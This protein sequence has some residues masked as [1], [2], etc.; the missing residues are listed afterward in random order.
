MRALIL[1]LT[2]CLA[3]AVGGGNIALAQTGDTLARADALAA[4][5]NVRGALALYEEAARDQPGSSEAFARLGGMQLLDQRYSEAV[6]SFQR[7][8]SLGDSGARPF[9]G[10]GMAYLHMGQLDLARAAFVEARTRGADASAE[11]ASVIAWIDSRRD[12]DAS[13]PPMH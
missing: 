10:M 7:A 4:E 3:T 12:G 1:A 8:V 11:L 13:R 5:G 9:I 2:L 6:R